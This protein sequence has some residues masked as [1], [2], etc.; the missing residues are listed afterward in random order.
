MEVIGSVFVATLQR[1]GDRYEMDS[2]T[3]NTNSTA[4]AL[5]ACYTVRHD[6]LE[7]LC[8]YPLALAVSSR[9]SAI[10]WRSNFDL[11]KCR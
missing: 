9:A 1:Y 6:R 11:S 3:R 10:G 2:S 8:P 7:S 5:P 4:V